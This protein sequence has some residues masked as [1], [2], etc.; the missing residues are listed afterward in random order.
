MHDRLT[1]EQPMS[2][3]WDERIDQRSAKLKQL[4]IDIVNCA[5]GRTKP[6]AGGR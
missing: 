6:S 2:R 5:C 3:V 1:G 4:K